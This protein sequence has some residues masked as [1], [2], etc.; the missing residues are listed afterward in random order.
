MAAF[1]MAMCSKAET[2]RPVTEFS[3][4][5]DGGRTI[6]K[7][8]SS[9]VRNGSDDS[10][11]SLW[12][13]RKNAYI[14]M[15][16]E[17][18]PD[19]IGMQ[20]AKDETAHDLSLLTEYDIF[21][22]T[23][24]DGSDPT[25]KNGHLPPNLIMYKTSCFE[26]LD[27]GVFY[28]N[29]KDPMQP[30]HYPL[31]ATG[32]QVRGCVWMKLKVK[33]NGHLIYFFDTHYTHDPEM[34]DAAGNKIYNIEPRRR[35]SE[36]LVSMIESIVDDQKASIFVVGDLN[37]SLYDGATRNGPYSLEPLKEYMWSAREEAASY[38]GAVSF[39]GFNPDYNKKIGN[40]DHIFYRG[41]E[42]V[43]FRTINGQDYGKRFIS[44]HYPV[45]CTFKL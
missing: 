44:D 32:W 7:V 9:N 3:T 27:A 31:G 5:P 18:Q 24:Y 15:L 23:E 26:K 37:C 34:Y 12:C 8:M 19:I 2:E 33:A 10:G 11:D 20:E 38:D 17:V 29:D 41:A 22:V 6:I 4:L 39:N 28:Y 40:I 35:A 43:D 13:N 25:V 16:S 21:R 45:T 14:A 42:A 1:S 30:V 36:M